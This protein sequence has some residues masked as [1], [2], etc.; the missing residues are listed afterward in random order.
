MKPRWRLH[1]QGKD[2]LGEKNLPTGKSD[3][4]ETYHKFLIGEFITADMYHSV[5]G[6][7]VCGNPKIEKTI[8]KHFET[9]SSL[10]MPFG[11]KCKTLGNN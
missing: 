3:D 11:R 10:G 6:H 2:R 7:Y 4:K 5:F 9:A 1:P 8:E